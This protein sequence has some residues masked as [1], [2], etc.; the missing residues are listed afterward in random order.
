MKNTLAILALAIAAVGTANAQGAAAAATSAPAYDPNAD[1]WQYPTMME[2]DNC[3]DIAETVTRLQQHITYY[4]R[5]E[6]TPAQVTALLKSRRVVAAPP[7]TTEADYAAYGEIA[8]W[9]RWQGKSRHHIY[10]NLL[11]ECLVNP[12]DN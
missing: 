6:W 9:P 1:Y 10:V 4:E 12:G 8:L 3:K 7:L 11:S 5:K 2:L